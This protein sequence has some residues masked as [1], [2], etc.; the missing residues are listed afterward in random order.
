MPTYSFKLRTGWPMA[1]NVYAIT[2]DRYIDAAAVAAVWLNISPQDLTADECSEESALREVRWTGHDYG[3]PPTKR[4][5][6]R[7]RTWNTPWG[8]WEPFP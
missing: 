7:K 6:V 2:A 8:E 3:N 4:M 5:E 1:A